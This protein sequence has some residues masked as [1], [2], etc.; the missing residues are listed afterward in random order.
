MR[1][2][3]VDGVSRDAVSVLDYADPRLQPLPEKMFNK[4]FMKQLE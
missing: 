2:T 1:V 4:N 3:L